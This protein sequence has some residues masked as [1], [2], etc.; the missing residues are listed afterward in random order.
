MKENN[1]CDEELV[2]IDPDEF[3]EKVGKYLGREKA[4]KEEIVLSGKI[5]I[6]ISLLAYVSVNNA[7]RLIPDIAEWLENFIYSEKKIEW[8]IIVRLNN[9]NLDEEALKSSI[10]NKY[11]EKIKIFND[12]YNIGFG[13]GH[14]KNI[15]EST[16]DFILILNDDLGFRDFKWLEDGLNK[17]VK[18]R[19][20]ALVGA[21]NNPKSITKNF[22]NGEHSVTELS[23]SILYCEASI[24][25]ASKSIL[26][27]IGLF[28]EDFNWAMFEDS[29]LSFRVQKNGYKI[30]WIEIPH[31]HYRST[32]VN[33]IPSQ[34][35]ASIIETNRAKFF[36]KWNYALHNDIVGNYA[37]FEIKSDGIGDILCSLIALKNQVLKNKCIG[38]IK[39]I[40]N[41]KAICRLFFNEDELIGIEEKEVFLKEKKTS[42]SSFNSI[43]KVNYSLPYNIHILLSA[44]LGIQCVRLEDTKEIINSL[45]LNSDFRTSPGGYVVLHLD[46]NRGHAGRIPSKHIQDDI[47]NTSKKLFSKIIIISNNECK[48]EKSDKVEYFNPYQKIDNLFE[49]IKGASFFIGI[50]SLPFHVAQLYNIRSCVFFGS[51]NPLSRVLNMDITIPLLPSVECIGCYHDIIEPGIPHCMRGDRACESTIDSKQIYQSIETMI[52]GGYYSWG[53]VALQFYKKQS[54]FLL[55]M[56]HH[57]APPNHFIRNKYS[58]EDTS[59]KIYNILNTLIQSK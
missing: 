28:D 33:S 45:N 27:K 4:V 36:A 25:L 21:S 47:L 13:A 14:N 52:N 5:K 23:S 54:E 34:T 11:F 55:R 7:I 53:K 46:S 19:N 22:G 49:L 1:Y 12:N 31:E 3:Y 8:E 56:I 37:I 9:N 15:S 24:L 50:D 2:G 10:P 30:G 57:P 16:G 43:S 51:V 38:K 29:D 18:N 58:N 17:I 39:I 35:K 40:T 44:A 6:S 41:N 20:I 48:L 42:I 59:N 32:S 26:D